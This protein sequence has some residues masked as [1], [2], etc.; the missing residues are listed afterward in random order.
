MLSK[1]YYKNFFEL[2]EDCNVRG[3]YYSNNYTFQGDKEEEAYKLIINHLGNEILHSD[4]QLMKN[5]QIDENFI[6]ELNDFVNNVIENLNFEYDSSYEN[7]LN[8]YYLNDIGEALSNEEIEKMPEPQT[9]E[10]YLFGIN[11]ES[12]YFN[13]EDLIFKDYENF[14]DHDY[15]KKLIDLL[16]VK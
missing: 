15:M 8:D 7:Y 3:F 1:Y 6:D 11:G 9:K 2:Y 14:K 13:L 12:D 4:L 10:E 16:E 5:I